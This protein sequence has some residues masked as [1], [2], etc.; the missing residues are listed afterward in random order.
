MQSEVM[1]FIIGNCNRINVIFIVRFY[2][3]ARAEMARICNDKI[4]E[5]NLFIS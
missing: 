2:Y 4:S 3:A 5:N 1:N